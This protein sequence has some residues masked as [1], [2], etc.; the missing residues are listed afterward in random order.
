MLKILFW[1][2]AR[3]DLSSLVS[4]IAADV[5]ANVV[6]LNENAANEQDT[7]R[8]LQAV[9]PNFHIPQTISTDRFHC[10]S[11]DHSL[12]LKEVHSGFR[13]SI[14]TLRFANQVALLGI[15]HGVDIR[16]NDSATRQSFAQRLALDLQF[17]REQQMNNRLILVGDFNMNPYESGM[18]IAAGLNAMM[19]R[20]CTTRGKAP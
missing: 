6:V 13:T 3:K 10:F 8:S 15:V 5:S 2:V 16:N 4:A 18:N 20:A 19:T 1:N 7:L 17:V 11:N 12:D 9:S 14:R